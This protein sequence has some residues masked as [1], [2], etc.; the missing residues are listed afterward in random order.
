MLSVNTP[1]GLALVFTNKNDL[2]TVV[3]HLS[4]YLDHST[5][6]DEEVFVYVISDTRIPNNETQYFAFWLKN[7]FEAAKRAASEQK[8]LEQEGKSE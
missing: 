1:N 3:D 4:D 2:A 6:G 5:E 8:E 7:L